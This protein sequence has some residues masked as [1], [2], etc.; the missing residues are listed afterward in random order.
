MIIVVSDVHLGYDKS[1]H[2][3]FK[4]F[5]DKCNTSDIDHLILLGD[6]FDFWR[7]NMADVVMGKN[8]CGND[9]GTQKSYAAI[10]ETL[11]NL[12]TK[13]VHYV[14]GNHD[15]YIL[16]LSEMYQKNYNMPVYPFTTISKSLRLSDGDC[17]FYFIHGYE[18]DVLLN[19]E[20]MDIE[21][22]EQ[23]S[24]RMCFSEKFLRILASDIWDIVQYG[25]LA[26]EK[27]KR[28]PHE[29]ENI[30]KIKELSE[31]NGVFALLGMKPDEKLV[32]GHTHRPFINDKKTVANTGSWVSDRPSEFPP[33]TYIK[34]VDGQMEWKAFDENKPL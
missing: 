10:F 28:P 32:F 25:E 24:Y 8:I 23:L 26:M 30:D 17:K 22:Y 6:I 27:L 16:S 11:G 34:I 19:M 1:N 5:L 18:L 20:F 15:Y 4:K 13:K 33:N 2:S 7:A 21:T 31:S 14:S 12:K 3:E 29:R 9:P